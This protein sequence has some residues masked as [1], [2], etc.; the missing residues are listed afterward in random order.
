MSSGGGPG[1]AKEAGD[2]PSNWVVVVSDADFQRQL[3]SVT[4][5]KLVVC[6][7]YSPTCPHCTKM[8]PIVQRMAATYERALFLYVDVNKC[9]AT[10]RV[11]KVGGCA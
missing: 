3:G 4:E 9:T 10:I 11:H 2:H 8:T 5:T 7:F 1:G 6:Y